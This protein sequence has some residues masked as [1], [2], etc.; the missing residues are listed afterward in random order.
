MDPTLA[1]AAAVIGYIVFLATTMFHE[2]GHALAARLLGSREVYPFPKINWNPLDHMARARFGLG[3]MP[4]IAMF[5]NMRSGGVWTFGYPAAPFDP[6]WAVQNKR[7]AAWIAFGGPALNL[8]VALAAAGL[9]KSGI[10]LG[11]FAHDYSGTPWLLVKA[12]DPAADIAAVLLSIL[13]YQN[14]LM[15]AF[16]LMPLPPL[17]GFSLAAFWMK[18]E[19]ALK[20]YQWESKLSFLYPLAVFH[21]TALFWSVMSRF[22]VFLLAALF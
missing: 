5:A 1:G 7:S 15:A 18:P 20:F 10:A 4:L 12:A 17:D 22:Y 8:A 6:Q 14:V 19:S 9:I 11:W 3:V 2:M 16:N 13:F 21:A